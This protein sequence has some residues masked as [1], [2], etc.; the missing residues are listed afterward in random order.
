MVDDDDGGRWA[1]AVPR[2]GL[3]RREAPA[4][5]LSQPETRR[6]GLRD[7]WGSGV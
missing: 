2:S 3:L 6:W 4:G 7:F 1:V 5:E